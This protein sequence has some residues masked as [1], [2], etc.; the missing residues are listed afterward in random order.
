MADWDTVTDYDLAAADYE[1]LRA[2]GPET[3]RELKRV[4]LL[5]PEGAHVL[6]IGCGTGQYE[7]AVFGGK[8][9]V[10]LDKSERMLRIARSRVERC[11]H[12]DMVDL[13][14]DDGRFDGV[15]FVHSLHHVGATLSISQ[16]ERDEARKTALREAS[17]VL[18][19][20]PI[21][22]V[23]RDPSQNE[24]VWFWK[25]FPKALETKLVIQPRVEV[26][27]EWLCELGIDDVKARPVDDPMIAGFYTAEAPLRPA[28]QR[29]FSEFS[30]LTP[31]ELAQGV[32]RLCAAIH[33]GH[34]VQEI[35]A[36]KRRFAEIGGTVF[37]LSGMKRR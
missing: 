3:V 7:E 6:S 32:K 9:V 24:A 23:Q 18:K 15:Y 25:Y 29:S 36:C 26:L 14:F 16:T 20:G 10:G 4:F 37:V 31:S 33:A 22:I 12:A 35:D 11:V 34:V 2:A 27:Q 21:A 30:Y 1:S 17:R 19:E 8:G 28:F 13:P 5:V